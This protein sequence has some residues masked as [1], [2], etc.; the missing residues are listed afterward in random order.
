M[1][2][3]GKRREVKGNVDET[4][5]E[6]DVSSL[7]AGNANGVNSVTVLGTGC[8]SCRA[9]HKNAVEAVKN[10]GLNLDVEYVSDLKK[11][12]SYGVTSMPV[13][14]VDGKVV[15]SGRV[16]KTSQIEAVLTNR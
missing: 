4:T 5:G 1:N 11:I 3:F 16:L 7:R 9:L 6:K 13:L 14:L 8:S 10:L 12:M 2:F 15:A